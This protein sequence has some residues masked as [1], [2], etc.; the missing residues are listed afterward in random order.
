MEMEEDEG[1]VLQVACL[2][3]AGGDGG[4]A[5]IGVLKVRSATDS[6]GRYIFRITNYI[7]CISCC[8][9]APGKVGSALFVF[10]TETCQDPSNTFT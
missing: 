9:I 5:L 10:E 1:M 2:P 7:S 3:V 6:C 4:Q 8:M